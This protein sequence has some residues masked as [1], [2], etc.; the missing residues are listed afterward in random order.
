MTTIQK[1]KLDLK[2]SMILG[3][4]SESNQAVAV[5]MINNKIDLIWKIIF[6]VYIIYIHIKNMNLF[7]FFN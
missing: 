5:L 1:K 2:K 6:E 3:E 4:I 7:I